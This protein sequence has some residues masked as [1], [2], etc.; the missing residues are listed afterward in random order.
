MKEITLTERQSVQGGEL[1]TYAGNLLAYYIK[2][3]L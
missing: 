1:L 2:K 3:H